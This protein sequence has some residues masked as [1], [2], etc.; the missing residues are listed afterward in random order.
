MFVVDVGFL[1]Y[2]MTA[3]S[4]VVGIRNFIPDFIQK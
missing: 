4:I 1:Q 2:S 3:K